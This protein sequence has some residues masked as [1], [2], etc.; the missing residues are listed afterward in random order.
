M[1]LIA[2]MTLKANQNKDFFA[3]LLE[4]TAL[5][6]LT[7]AHAASS[8]GQ[9]VVLRQ[10]GALVDYASIESLHLL[11]EGIPLAQFLAEHTP[12]GD[13]FGGRRARGVA[14]AAAEIVAAALAPFGIQVTYQAYVK[15][16]M[17]DY[18]VLQCP[19]CKQLYHAYQGRG[20]LTLAGESGG[21]YGIYAAEQGACACGTPLVEA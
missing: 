18:I 14:P 15:R 5:V 12:D 19:E 10:D 21:E 8:Y 9:P 4:N 7:T 13:G 17:E 3:H 2:T 16:G 11:E 6:Q 1:D 20:E